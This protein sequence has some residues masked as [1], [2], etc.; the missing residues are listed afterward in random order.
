MRSPVVG[1]PGRPYLRDYRSRRGARP[2]WKLPRE[3]SFLLF[4]AELTTAGHPPTRVRD[5][6]MSGG[7]SGGLPPLSTGAGSSSS[8]GPLLPCSSTSTRTGHAQ[9]DAPEA[10]GRGRRSTSFLQLLHRRSRDL[11]TSP[12]SA[13][14][15]RAGAC[16]VSNWKEPGPRRVSS[17]R[18]PCHDMPAPSAQLRPI[19]C[20]MNRWTSASNSPSS[21]I[22]VWIFST[23]YMTVV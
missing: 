10:T 3:R 17:R 20:S 18:G 19:N 21:S 14:R 12:F 15:G 23:A 9:L 5:R 2:P 1:F 6:G 11:C 16:A 13:P 7:Q 22:R 4:S 8:R